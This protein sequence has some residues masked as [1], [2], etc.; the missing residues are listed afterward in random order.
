MLFSDYVKTLNELLESDPESGELE[1]VYI[2]NDGS[3][4]AV[5]LPSNPGSL[6]KLGISGKGKYLSEDAVEEHFKNTSERVLLSLIV[7][8]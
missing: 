2:S 7:I 3:V 1:T 4:E 8:N 5:Y 6:T